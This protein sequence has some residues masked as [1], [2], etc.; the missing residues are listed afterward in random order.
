[1]E[2]QLKNL[3]FHS[4]LFALLA[5]PYN[6]NSEPSSSP[7]G[8]TEFCQDTTLFD[9]DFGIDHARGGVMLVTQMPLADQ[10]IKL[11]THW[12]DGDDNNR[13]VSYTHVIAVHQLAGRASA[14]FRVP[15]PNFPL[16]NK[17][18]A[19]FAVCNPSLNR[20]EVYGGDGPV[21]RTGLTNSYGVNAKLCSGPT[22]YVPQVLGTVWA[23]SNN[24][25]YSDDSTP[26][27]TLEWYGFIL[28]K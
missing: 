2:A 13:L 5:I 28:L 26:P 11:C 16:P 15:N 19:E 17:S 7:P 1:M 25:N 14:T 23:R 4:L 9:H 22:P 18:P 12:L 10:W 8:P 20:A 21:S 3:I 24:D 27:G 6:A